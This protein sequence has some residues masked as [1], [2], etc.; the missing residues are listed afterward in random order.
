MRQY[1]MDK[2]EKSLKVKHSDA[3]ND[4]IAK[5]LDELTEE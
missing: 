1:E 3:G 5:V 4:E 2:G